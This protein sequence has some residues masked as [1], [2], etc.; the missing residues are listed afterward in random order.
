MISRRLYE[1]VRTHDWFAVAL[2]FVI[3][4]VGVFLGVQVSNWNAA[5]V[6]RMVLE[7][8][9]LDI[10]ADIRLDLAEIS[11]VKASALERIGISEYILEQAGV[12][13]IA[14][15]VVLSRASADDAL[16]GFETFKIPPGATPREEERDRL[17]TLATS[18][19]MQDTN[20]TTF[21]A[22]IS[23]GKIELIRDDELMRALRDYYYLVNATD[24]TQTRSIVVMRNYADQVGIERGLAPGAVIDE[25]VLVDLVTADRT[26]SATLTATRERAALQLLLTSALEEKARELLDQIEAERP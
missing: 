7:S 24:R 26:L 12:T 4:V 22:L 2:D 5:R 19:Y 17:W 14:A 3:V 9:L 1:H 23:S 11:R 10:A 18:T 8:Y 13:N 16:Q 21:D 20:R 25:K 15:E 6:D